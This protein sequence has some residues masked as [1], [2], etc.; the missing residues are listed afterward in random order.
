MNSERFAFLPACRSISARSVSESVTEVL[1][2]IPPIY[3]LR[4]VTAMRPADRP[5]S[6]VS[7]TPQ[8]SRVAAYTDLDRG[9][10]DC[11]TRCLSASRTSSLVETPRSA[12]SA[13]TWARSLGS[14]L[15]VSIG[16]SGITGRYYTTRSVSRAMMDLERNLAVRRQLRGAP[17]APQRLD[18][19]RGRDEPPA[20]NADRGALV[21]ELGG[22]HRHHVDVAHDARL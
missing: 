2:F 4:L 11:A 21:A 6:D 9:R 22:L 1:T 12:A 5:G 13:L 19:R 7:A 8:R 17:P 16:S 20:Q 14:I 3:Y 15:T 10:F 18:E